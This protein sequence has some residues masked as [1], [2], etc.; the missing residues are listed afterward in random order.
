MTNWVLDREDAPKHFPKSN[1]HPKKV[2]VTVWWTVASLIHYNFL[3]P[4]KIITSEKYA[5]QINEMHWKWQHLQQVNRMDPIL[6][7]DN[8]RLHITQPMLQKWTN[9]AT[10]FCLIRLIPLSSHDYHFF[11]H[12]NNFLS[13]KQLPQP[14]GGGKCIPRVFES[15]NMPFYATGINKLIS[16]WQKCVDGNG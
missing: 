6:L 5:Q 11:R 3:N 15:W 1:F 16:L 12:L 2:M 8:A 7:Y 9:W 10:T 13:G 4:D 14:A